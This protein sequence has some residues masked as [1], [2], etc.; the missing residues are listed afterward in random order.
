MLCRR[1]F[2]CQG[3][4]Y[5]ESATYPY[6]ERMCEGEIFAVRILYSYLTMKMRTLTLSVARVT[7]GWDGE[8]SERMLGR[9]HKMAQEQNTCLLFYTLS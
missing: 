3:Y 7:A 4:V 9:D 6:I 8:E 5:Q 1:G 2:T